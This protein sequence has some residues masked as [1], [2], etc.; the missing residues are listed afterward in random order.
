MKIITRREA[1]ELGLKRYFTGKPCGRGHITER[2]VNRG[3]CI[4]CI[5]HI[6]KKNR[7]KINEQKKK[8]YIKN[9]ETYRKYR[10]EN[11]EKIN[12]KKKKYRKKHKSKINK[13]ERKLYLINK[14]KRKRI[15]KEYRDRNIEL[16]RQR[17][18]DYRAKHVKQERKWLKDQI[19]NL[20]DCYIKQSLRQNFNLKTNQITPELIEMKRE[21][22]KQYRLQKAIAKQRGL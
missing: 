17:V 15:Q 1:K 6:R 11:K 10:K 2:E 3:G 8:N 13:R 5:I 20:G 18:R 12:E 16:C 14:V 7:D 19:K 21:Q 22:I 9:I 4:N